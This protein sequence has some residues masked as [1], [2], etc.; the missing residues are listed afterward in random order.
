MHWEH[1]HHVYVRKRHPDRQLPGMKWEWFCNVPQ[2]AAYGA[3]KYW[4][5]TM[6]KAL[7][8]L[9]LMHLAASVVTKTKAVYL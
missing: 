8:H 5:R 3:E 6:R 1:E 2:C 4:K 7:E 9:W